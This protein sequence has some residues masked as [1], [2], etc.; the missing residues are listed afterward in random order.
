MSLGEDFARA[1]AAKDHDHVRRLLHP[2][3]DGPPLGSAFDRTLLPGVTFADDQ[4]P[5]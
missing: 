1:V 4:V 2:A 5:V 3:L